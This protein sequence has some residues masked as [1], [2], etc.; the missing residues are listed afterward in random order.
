MSGS[1]RSTFE[2]PAARSKQ[3]V[4]K[5]FAEALDFPAYFGHNL[6]ALHDLLRD[7]AE[8]LSEPSTLVWHIDPEFK[9]SK[10]Y[11]SVLSILRELESEKF[12]IVLRQPKISKGATKPE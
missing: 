3:G 9:T 6:D 5:A 2:V 1:E 12:K 7:F 8:G 11:Q 4:L 10:A